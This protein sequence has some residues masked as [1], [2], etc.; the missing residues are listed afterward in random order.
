MSQ[1]LLIL[2]YR[3]AHPAEGVVCEYYRYSWER[4]ALT[5]KEVERRTLSDEGLTVGGYTVLTGDL[6]VLLSAGR[7][8]SRYV[9][10]DA[11]HPVEMRTGEREEILREW[12]SRGPLP[13]S[14]ASEEEAGGWKDTGAKDL[15]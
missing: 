10:P 3:C 4:M 12:S 2:L 5:E 13:A 7:F 11:L 14:P 15:L 8:H 6:L 9:G 1:T